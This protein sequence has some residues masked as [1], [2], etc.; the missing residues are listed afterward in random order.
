MTAVPD[1]LLAVDALDAIADLCRSALGADSPEPADLEQALFATANPDHAPAMVRG[2]PAVGLVATVRRAGGG[3]IRLLAVHPDHRRRG[4]GTALLAVAESDLD[5]C[6][7]AVVGA[8]APDYLFPGVCTRMT[9]MLCLMEA[10]RYR[11]GDVNLNMGVDLTGLAPD[12]GG[13]LLATDADADEVRAWTQTHWPSWTDEVMRALAKER[14]LISRDGQGV[15]GFCA[16]DVNR[17]GWLGP[18]AVRPSE[19]GGRIGVPLLMG[20]LHRMRAD[21]RRHA[22]ISW[23][24]PVRFYVRNAGATISDAYIVHRRRI[25]PRPTETP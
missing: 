6:S 9:E 10:R 8:D 23:I 20:A 25:S 3:Y 11:R 7:H 17:A 12:P 2:D 1:D 14:L 5:G 18:I 21:G 24:S 22:E 15:A 4:V 16:W 13:A 19:V